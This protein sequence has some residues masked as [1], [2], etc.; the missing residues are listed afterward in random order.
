MTGDRSGQQNCSARTAPIS[1]R[2]ELRRRSPFSH[3]PA[4]AV[5][6]ALPARQ[7]CAVMWRSRHR[8][9]CDSA[10]AQV[11][12]VAAGVVRLI[13]PHPVRSS[14]RPSRA[15]SGHPYRRQTGSAIVTNSAPG[16]VG[17]RS[18]TRPT[19]A[20]GML[21]SAG[22]IASSVT[23]PWPR[24]T[25]SSQSDT[26][27]PCWS[28]SSA[29]G[30]AEGGR[31]ADVSPNALPH[32]PAGGRVRMCVDLLGGGPVQPQTVQGA[33]RTRG[34]PSRHTRHHPSGD[35]HHDRSAAFHLRRTR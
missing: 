22:S 6:S 33:S 4:L 21:P 13:G 16:A 2:F 34:R 18:S 3:G 26:R 11:G 19:T 7:S 28:Q 9:H 27:R 20:S 14:A 10:S 25:T 29:S 35:P 31:R 24:D 17:L 15:E 8:A 30:C 32:G 23:G 5:H 1:L 12:P